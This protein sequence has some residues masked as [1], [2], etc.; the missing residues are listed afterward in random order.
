MFWGE[1]KIVEETYLQSKLLSPNEARARV[2]Y[3]E[4]K[5]L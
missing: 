2:H 4:F 5:I 1:R 3:I